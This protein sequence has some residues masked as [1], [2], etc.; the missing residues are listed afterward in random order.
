M[1][2]NNFDDVQRGHFLK[3][4]FLYIILMHLSIYSICIYSHLFVKGIFH[5]T[6]QKFEVT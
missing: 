2:K 5:T 3:S 1:G 6:I 4:T